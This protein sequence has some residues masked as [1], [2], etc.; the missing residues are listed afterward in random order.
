MT[1]RTTVLLAFLLVGCPSPCI[2]EPLTP[3]AEARW[4][5]RYN[6]DPPPPSPPLGIPG[7]EEVR[8]PPGLGTYAAL[9]LFDETGGLLNERWLDGFV[10]WEEASGS[11]DA[12]S[13]LPTQTGRS[14]TL[15]SATG[16]RPVVRLDLATGVVD[17][18]PIHPV[19]PGAGGQL[20]DLAAFPDG[21]AL[22]TRARDDLGGGR[23]L[24]RVDGFQVQDALDLSGLSLGVVEPGRI[25]ALDSQTAVVGLGLPDEPNVGAVAWVDGAGRVDRID[26]PELTN[27]FDVA[28]FRDADRVAILCSGD[29]TAP[30]RDRVG[31]G[32]AL[33][34]L[35]PTGPPRFVTTRPAS[36]LFPDA[37]PTRGLVALEGG[38]VAAV[39]GGTPLDGQDDVLYAV[40]LESTSG[41]SLLWSEAWTPGLGAALGAGDFLPSTGELWWPSATSGVLRWSKDGSA[42]A[43]LP[44]ASAPTCLGSP[45]R[46]VRALP[47]G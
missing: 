39:S 6:A 45:P 30:P 34:E 20:I 32:F 43:A 21:T 29:V 42:F 27:C 13:Y 25:A 15:L 18:T 47:G 4:V 31:A 1:L 36:T 16:S 44:N 12:A 28:A 3:A 38:W 7:I 2:S 14:L 9:A 46:V 24:V 37:P 5:A 17:E 26:V 11:V 8:D 40:D 19:Y 33:L 22:S 41:G 35:S 10:Q 23:D